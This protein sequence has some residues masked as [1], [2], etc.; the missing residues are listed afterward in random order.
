MVAVSNPKSEEFSVLRTNLFGDLFAALANNARRGVDDVQVFELGRVFLHPGAAVEPGC[1]PLR[2]TV[3][4]RRALGGAL[5]GSPWTSAWNA[6]PHLAQADFF[7]LKGL[8]DELAREFIGECLTYEAAVHPCLHPGRSAIVRLGGEE[9]GW[10]G[11]A[12]PELRARYDIPSPAYVF[13]IDFDLLVAHARG[14]A[15]YRPLSRFPAVG[16]DLALV[17]PEGTP[18]ARVEAIIAEAGGD[19]IER[20]RLFDLYQG[21]QVPAGHKS[22]AYSLVLRAP[23]RTLVDEEVSGVMAAITVALSTQIQAQIRQ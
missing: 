11:E 7:L 22:L 9:L 5:M 2:A 21:E 4:E 17:V 8:V 18:A 19:L 13:E 6:D 23:D 12:H 15:S 3:I 20:I 10:V 16:R 14:E 1:D